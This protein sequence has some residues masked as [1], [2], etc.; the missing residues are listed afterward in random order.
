MFNRKRESCRIRPGVAVRFMGESIA[1]AKRE[2][3]DGVVEN[4]G[5]G[6]MFISTDRLFPKG[7]LITMDFRIDSESKDLT[8]VSAQGMVR[9]VQRGNGNRGMGIAFIEFKGLGD[10]VFSSWIKKVLDE[11][12]YG[13]ENEPMVYLKIAAFAGRVSPQPNL[14]S[15]IAG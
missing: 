1:K 9:W 7:S 15:A 12:E 6:G 3:L 13:D 10:R 5:L 8:P 14:S 11:P 4:C 2:Y